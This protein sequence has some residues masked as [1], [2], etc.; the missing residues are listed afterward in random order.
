MMKLANVYTDSRLATGVKDKIV[1][2]PP[3]SN[4]PDK[5]LNPGNDQKVFPPRMSREPMCCF[6]CNEIGHKTQQSRKGRPPTHSAPNP[7]HKDKGPVYASVCLTLPIDSV[8]NINAQP[9]DT[10]AG[11]FV[12]ACCSVSQGINLP[13][14]Q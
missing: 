9:G 7:R 2:L 8:R 3:R 4:H 12:L 14:V 11:D 5:T 13:V 6:L 1:A 10:E